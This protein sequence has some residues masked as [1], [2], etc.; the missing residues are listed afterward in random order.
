MANRSEPC[1]NTK[2]PK[3]YLSIM[4]SG[5]GGNYQGHG[6]GKEQQIDCDLHILRL[7]YR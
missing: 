4:C 7:T 5:L 3:C 2:E 1:Y 6:I